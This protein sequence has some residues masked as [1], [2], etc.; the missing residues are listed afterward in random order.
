[1]KRKPCF[2][3]LL[4]AAV[5]LLSACGLGAPAERY[6]LSLWYV[7]EEPLAAPLSLLLKSY[8]EQSGLSVSL[9]PFSDTESLTKALD[10]GLVPD[11]LLGS[12]ELAFSLYDKGLLAEGGAISPR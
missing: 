12:H 7:E 5:L 3:A 6:T 2:L 8:P 10:S 1:M 11:L 9:R 4:L